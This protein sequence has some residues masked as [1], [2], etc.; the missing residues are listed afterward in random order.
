[1]ITNLIDWPFKVLKI[2]AACC[3]IVMIVMVFGNVVLRYGFN[4]GITVSEELSSWGLTWMT[5]TAGLIALREHGHLGFDAV[6]T[7]FPPLV[8]RILLT[9]AHVL[10]IWMMW[11]F[12]DGSWQQTVINLNNMAPASGISLAVLYGVG[13]LFGVIAI[14]VLLGDLYCIVTGRLT[15]TLASEAGEA[16]AE[17]QRHSLD[18][19]H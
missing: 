7:K 5:Y 3:L 14:L 9:I 13:I 12:L 16:L 8:Q 15:H 19:T 18:D 1:L 2:F 10:M 6:L 17:A 11:L 4:S